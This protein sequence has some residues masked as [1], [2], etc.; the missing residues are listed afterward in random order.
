LQITF[1]T[2]YKRAIYII[3]KAPVCIVSKRIIKNNL[4]P[5]LEIQKVSSTKKSSLI[6]KTLSQKMQLSKIREII[7][8]RKETLN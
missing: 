4:S 5:V 8:K 2:I 6:L 3:G 1:G 7:G